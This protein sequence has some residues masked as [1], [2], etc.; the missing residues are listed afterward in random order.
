MQR[1]KIFS[2]IIFSACLFFACTGSTSNN[3][4]T[5]NNSAAAATSGSGDDYYYEITTATSGKSMNIN[6]IIKMY[7]SSKGAIRSEMNITNSASDKSAPIVLIGSADKPNESILL[8]DSAK[9]FTVNHIDSGDF[10]NINKV[11]STVTKIGEEKVL[12]F[13]CVHARI[14][15]NKTMGSFFSSTDTIDLW[16]SNDVPMQPSVKNLMSQFESRTGNTMYSPEA[17]TQLTQMGCTGFLVKLAM[18]SKDV[19]MTMQ[20]TKAQRKDLD[21]ALFKIPAGYTE[22]KSGL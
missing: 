19:A 17:E 3:T 7:V 10:N 15:S 20:L 22:D 6:G 5:S 13:N 11:Q 2:A 1:F 21:A 8:D 9:T 12:G 16:K 18:K 4:D 14:I